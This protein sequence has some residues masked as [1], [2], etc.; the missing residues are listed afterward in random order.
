MMSYNFIGTGCLKILPKFGV[1]RLKQ[2][3]P[4]GKSQINELGPVRFSRRRAKGIFNGS[5]FIQTAGVVLKK[6]FPWADSGSQP[7]TTP[8]L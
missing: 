6:I 3:L 5:D 8:Y 7:C 2:F 4:D 1:H